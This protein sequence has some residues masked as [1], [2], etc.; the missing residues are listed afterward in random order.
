MVI[1]ITRPKAI[2]ILVNL[3]QDKIKQNKTKQNKTKQNKIKCN[4]FYNT[5]TILFKKVL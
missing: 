5:F 4:Y 3:N 2:K 1:T